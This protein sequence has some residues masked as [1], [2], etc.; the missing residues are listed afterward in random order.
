MRSSASRL[1]CSRRPAPN[2]T[3]AVGSSF[4]PTDVTDERRFYEAAAG[5]DARRSAPAALRNRQP[6]AEVLREWLPESGLVLEVASGTG[7]HALYF[8][9]Q[10]PTLEWQPSDAHPQALV[11]IGAWREASGLR[12]VRPP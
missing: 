2:C 4:R 7:E 12:N 3:C 10:F 6:I 8:A 9:E 1:D 5:A 11:S